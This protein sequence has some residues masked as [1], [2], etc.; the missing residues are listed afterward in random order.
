[1]GV[2]RKENLVLQ[3][4]LF[5]YVSMGVH[6]NLKNFKIPVFLHRINVRKC[7]HI[8]PHLR[9]RKIAPLW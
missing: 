4:Y 7:V 6:R 8:I 9:K 1:M 3:N 5:I 2:H